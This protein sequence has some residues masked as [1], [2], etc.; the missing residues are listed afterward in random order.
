LGEDPE[1]P[2]DFPFIREGWLLEVMSGLVI[3]IAKGD[4]IYELWQEILSVEGEG[5]VFACV[6]FPAT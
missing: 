3:G 5:T 4:D 6:G 2:K 1:L